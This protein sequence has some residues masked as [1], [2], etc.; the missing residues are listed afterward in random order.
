MLI[1]LSLPTEQRSPEFEAFV[2]YYSQIVNSLP[3]EALSPHFVA[4]NIISPA[5]QMEICGVRSPIKAAGLLLSNISGALSAEFTGDFYKF[6]DIM[7][8]HGSS[9]SKTVTAAIR[10]KLLKS[11]DKGIS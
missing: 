8:Q 2:Y 9:D 4:Q 7:E 5:E 3:A 1:A 6:L 10:K 11:Q